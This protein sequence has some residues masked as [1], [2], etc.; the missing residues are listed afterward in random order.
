MLPGVSNIKALY[1]AAIR[2]IPISLASIAGQSFLDY[3]DGPQLAGVQPLA[4]EAGCKC[5]Y[6]HSQS[7]SSQNT[8]ETEPNK[9]G[10]ASQKLPRRIYCDY[11]VPAG[12]EWYTQ[13]TGI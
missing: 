5:L 4:H 2:R 8:G 9:T 6:G 12:R 7:Q 13:I 10:Q 11:V 1:T 3:R